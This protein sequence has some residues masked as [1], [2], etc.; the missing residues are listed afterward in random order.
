MAY[1]DSWNESLP[2]GSED[3]GTLDTIIQ[4]LK[5]SIRERLEDFFPDWDDDGVD[6]KVPLV[7]RASVS[8]SADETITTGLITA[9]P[10]DTEDV[11]TNEL[12]DI[13]GSPTRIT[14]TRAGF[15][16]VTA[17][18][19]WETDLTQER[20]IVI[21]KNGATF[22]ATDIRSATVVNNFG[23][24]TQNNISYLGHFAAAD[25]VEIW[26]HQ[27]TGGDLDVVDGSET[28]FAVCRLS[29]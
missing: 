15:Y 24:D 21:R 11:D 5:R 8:L 17:N 18:I 7:D 29:Y 22:L 26:V 3:S 4:G 6:P 1:T 14:M 28:Y 12:V 23:R 25:Y 2:D 13:A 27:D 19:R 10:W 16:I 9:I 20:T